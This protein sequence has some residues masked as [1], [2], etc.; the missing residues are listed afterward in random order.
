MREQTRPKDLGTLDG[1]RGRLILP[2][3]GEGPERTRRPDHRAAVGSPC[4][5]RSVREK[6]WGLSARL[7]RELGSAFGR[8]R[9]CQNAPGDY[10]S[11]GIMVL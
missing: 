11:H 2:V 1:S 7:A 10:P 9:Q 6:N 5:G 8:S 3:P 4:R